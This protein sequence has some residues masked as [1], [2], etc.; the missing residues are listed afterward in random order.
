MPDLLPRWRVGRGAVSAGRGRRSDPATNR[1][2]E[3]LLTLMLTAAGVI[4]YGPATSSPL[5]GTLLPGPS[6]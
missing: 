4:A 5:A 6:R 3:A 2:R 1:S